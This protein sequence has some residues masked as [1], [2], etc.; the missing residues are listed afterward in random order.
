MPSIETVRD[1]P[2][3]EL[4]DRDGERVGS[5]QEI[6]LDARTDEPEW[7]LVNTGLF[8]MKASFVPIRD[9]Q[10]R[11]EGVHVPYEKAKIK[12]APRVE[13][14]GE[15]SEEEEADLYRHYGLE[16][17]ESE[18]ELAQA[19]SGP[20]R[21]D[22]ADAGLPEPAAGGPDDTL[23]AASWPET[24]AEPEPAVESEPAVIGG[25]PEATDAAGRGPEPA[26]ATGAHVD[27]P[28]LAGTASAG[29]AR[30]AEGA[31]GPSRR[32]LRRYIV[33]EYVVR[34]DADGREQVVVDRQPLPEEDDQAPG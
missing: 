21:P 9:A 10:V 20:G 12:D 5:I 23:A 27:E 16:Y 13:P 25:E 33:T 18:E 7:A 28:A 19:W 14:D 34:S 2:G 26:R 24:S 6:Y 8:G 4:V 17:A 30:Q 31:P 15:L 11:G 29:T 32:R 22:Q 3:R 1:W